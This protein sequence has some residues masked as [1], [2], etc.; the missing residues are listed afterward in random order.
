VAAPIGLPA[1]L[2]GRVSEHVGLLVVAE[3]WLWWGVQGRRMAWARA[4]GAG[5]G[6]VQ[7]KGRRRR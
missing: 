1:V 2:S 5:E 6:P 3:L 7:A 4:D